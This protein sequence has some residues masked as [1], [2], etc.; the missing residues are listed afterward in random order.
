M[1]KSLLLMLAV[2]CLIEGRASAQAK[3]HYKLYAKLIGRLEAPLADGGHLQAE[4][5]D[6][7][8]VIMF[9]EQQSKAVLQLAG[10]SFLIT[11]DWITQVEENE[12][13]PEE[14][15]SYRRNVQAYLDWR[16]TQA[17]AALEAPK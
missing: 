3:K 15:A 16:A 9:K 2:V 8:P 10:T 14:V 4:K 5:G 7:F 13:S 1:V 12:L 17:K 6:V 11:T